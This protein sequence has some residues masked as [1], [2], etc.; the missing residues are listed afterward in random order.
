MT[1]ICLFQV[2]E[3]AGW[4]ITLDEKSLKAGERAWVTDGG[5]VMVALEDLVPEFIDAYAFDFDGWRITIVAGEFG[6]TARVT[7]ATMRRDGFA[8]TFK[9]AP[10]VKDDV[11]WFPLEALANL[12]NFSLVKDA[13]SEVLKI[14]SPKSRADADEIAAIK[15]RRMTS[16]ANNSV[17]PRPEIAYFE[18]LLIPGSEGLISA[19]LYN[20]EP[21]DTGLKSIFVNI[22]G[23]GWQVG[24]IA[25]SDHVCRDIA[26]QSGQKVLSIE[27][28][29]LPEHPFPIG[30]EDAYAITAWVHEN[31]RKLGIDPDRIVVGGDSAGGNIAN[32]VAMMARD[33]G[34]FDIA[35]VVLAYPALDMTGPWTQFVFADPEDAQS[36]YATPKNGVLDG[37]PQSLILVAEDDRLRPQGEEY[38]QLLGKVGVR[39]DFEVVKGTSHGF[40]ATHAESRARVGRFIRSIGK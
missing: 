6:I 18:D 15:K 20:P 3:A 5:Q 40:L 14:H 8:T 24:S 38:A 12:L 1:L 19:R 23:G 22:H 13:D 33:R 11:L 35:G 37:M 25:S 9:A 31:H 26:N 36:P 10:V 7:S 29:M 39:V 16:V 28:S 34:A 21:S 27:Y 32:A 17:Y 4:E 2:S 30:W